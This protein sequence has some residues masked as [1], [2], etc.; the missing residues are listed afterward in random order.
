MP[1]KRDLNDVWTTVGQGHLGFIGF[2][3][4][5]TVVTRPLRL[6]LTVHPSELP[7]D[8]WEAILKPLFNEIEL[9]GDGLSASIIINLES[10]LR[11]P[12]GL[13]KS[14]A[15]RIEQA[16]TSYFYALDRASQEEEEYICPCGHPAEDHY[17]GEEHCESPKCGCPE[18]GA[19]LAD[20]MTHTITREHPGGFTIVE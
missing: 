3:N 14:L 18:L 6:W 5:Q 1:L 17:L 4:G 12:A 13:L 16:H 2:Y 15:H 8:V 19:S 9:V 11:N 10:P 20:W 7:G